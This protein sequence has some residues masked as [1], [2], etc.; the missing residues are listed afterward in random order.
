LFKIS[1]RRTRGE[2]LS[3]GEFLDELKSNIKAS[4]PTFMK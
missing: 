3:E 1:S 4:D 2:S